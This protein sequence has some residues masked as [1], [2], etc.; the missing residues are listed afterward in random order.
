MILD[1]PQSAALK[2]H[3]QQLAIDFAGDWPERVLAELRGWCAIEKAR[4]MSTMTVEQ[5]RAGARTHPD[6]HQAWGS[7]PRLACAAG[8]IEPVFIPGT[9]QQVRVRA[10]SPKTHAHEVKVW[11]ILA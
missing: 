7:L 3:G 11:R 10:A 4:G 2:A 8:I 9:N 6:S 1:A 5:F